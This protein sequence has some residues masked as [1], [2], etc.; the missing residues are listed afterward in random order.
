MV[1]RFYQK[2]WGI[3]LNVFLLFMKQINE[4]KISMLMMRKIIMRSSFLKL[5]FRVQ[6]RIQSF[7]MCW[8]NWK[9]W[10]ICVMWRIVMQFMLLLYCI[11][12]WIVY[13][14]NWMQFGMIVR[15]LIM[16]ISDV[17]YWNFFWVN[18]SCM[19]QLI[20]KQIRQEMLIVKK[21]GCVIFIVM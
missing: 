16:F 5:D 9:I 19:M 3:F 8:I 12:G 13:I 18:I 1:M 17:M 6:I 21:V 20:V 10:R 4:E 7:G 11:F 15:M 2:L 14:M